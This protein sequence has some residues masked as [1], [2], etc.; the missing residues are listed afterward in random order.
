MKIP[1][2]TSK[3]NEINILLSLNSNDNS[4]IECNGNI[5]NTCGVND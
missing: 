2:I 3:N 5:V 1:Y 4:N